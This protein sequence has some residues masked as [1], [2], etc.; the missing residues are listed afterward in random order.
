MCG[1]AWGGSPLECR[2]RTPVSRVTRGSSLRMCGG[3]Q[4][5]GAEWLVVVDS[6]G[7]KWDAIQGGLTRL[8][9]YLDRNLIEL[10]PGTITPEFRVQV[11]RRLRNIDVGEACP[12]IPNAARSHDREEKSF[13]AEYLARTCLV[14]A[15]T[16]PSQVAQHDSGSAW[17][18]SPSRSD[19]FVRYTSP[20]Y[21]GAQ[22]ECR[23]PICD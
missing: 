5:C 11:S 6:D 10:A 21:P 9:T 19:S 4:C 14:D 22:G 16:R 23:D 2:D 12:R 13:A 15:S 18:A 1:S 17:V 7:G 20:V 8:P 3:A